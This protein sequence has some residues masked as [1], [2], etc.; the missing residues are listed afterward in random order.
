[1]RIRIRYKEILQAYKWKE[2]DEKAIING[3]T[4]SEWPN[5]IQLA[6][7]NLPLKY[8]KRCSIFVQRIEGGNELFVWLKSPGL[9]ELKKI[10][11][12]CYLIKRKKGI[13]SLLSEINF[14]EQYEEIKNN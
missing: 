8:T 7:R 4:L 2:N 14:K 13:I 6:I 10:E 1:M 9:Y 11:P 5:F 3:V 12:G